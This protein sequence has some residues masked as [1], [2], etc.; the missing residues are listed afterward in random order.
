MKD[1]EKRGYWEE[2]VKQYPHL[3]DTSYFETTTNRS[4]KRKINSKSS[5][6]I[7]S[8]KKRKKVQ[9]KIS[10]LHK[11]YKTLH[12]DSYMRKMK[13]NSNLF[14]E[15]HTLSK[16][17][18]LCDDPD[19]RVPNVIA[20]M[21]KTMFKNI[22]GLKKYKIADLGCGTY[23]LAQALY[24]KFQTRWNKK[25]LPEIIANSLTCI[26]VVDAREEEILS[27]DFSSDLNFVQNDIA[28]LQDIDDDVCDIVVLSRAMW[29]KNYGDVLDEA[30]RI[31]KQ[32]GKIIVCEP[33]KRWWDEKTSTN[34]LCKLFEK[35]G[36]Y[37]TNSVGLELDEDGYHSIF[38]YAI[39]TKD[40]MK[41]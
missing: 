41:L 16:K 26:D 2:F 15:Y 31:L 25:Q 34:R 30:W 17:L 35:K 28:D 11:T 10:E 40:E 33:F 36:W 38:F 37:L 24:D 7:L 22:L 9:S 3:F 32:G 21:I 18:D 4:S 6:L 13:K 19:D 1:E 29:A 14:K 12:S 20:G 39:F 5:S 8:K 27:C 23:S